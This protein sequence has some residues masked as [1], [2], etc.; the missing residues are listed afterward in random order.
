MTTDGFYGTLPGDIV[1]FRTGNLANTKARGFLPAGWEAQGT[2]P[3]LVVASMP[4][5][6]RVCVVSA[7]RQ[8]GWFS[9]SVIARR[10]IS[11]S[12]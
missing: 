11:T 3:C 1:W 12:K 7:R 6:E 2:E 9:T 5:E 8:I 10:Q 4:Y